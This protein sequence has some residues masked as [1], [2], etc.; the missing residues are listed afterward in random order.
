LAS[1]RGELSRSSRPVR[2]AAHCAI[3]TG[4]AAAAVTGLPAAH[5][6]EPS[7]EELVVTGTRIRQPGVVSSS[8]IYSVGAEEIERQQEPELE[9]ILRLLPVTAPSDGQNVNNGT[10]GAATIDLRGLGSQRTLVLMNGRRMVPFNDD[11]EVDTSMIP[12]ALIQRVDIITGGASAVYGSDAIAGAVNVVLKDDFEGVDIRMNTSQT[13]ESDGQDSWVGVTLGTNAAD[14]AGN[15]VLSLGYQ[16]RDPILLGDRPLGQLGIVTADGSG[17]S[18]YLAGQPPTPAP[19]GCGGPGSVAAGG[20]TTTVPTRV[21]IAGGP[22]LG[23]FRDDG[24]LQAN[25]GVFNFNPFNY[26]QTPLERYN[27]T[28]IGTLDLS[29]G[30]EVYSMFNYG[31]TKVEQQVAPSGV[32]GTGI[33]TPLS[34]PLIGA[35]ARALMISTAEA[36]RLAG[37]VNPAGIPNTST[38]DPNDFLFHNWTDTDGNG[39][40]SAG[41]DLNIQYRRRTGELGARSEDYNN[42][43]FQAVVGLRG[44]ISDNWDYDVSFQ[45][46][47]TNRVLKR[48]GYTN[49]TNFENA[50]QTLDG[51]T[52]LNGDATCVPINVFGGY[53]SITPAMAAYSGATALQQQ[54]Y[55][56]LIGQAF[57]TGSFENVQLPSASSPIA[58]SF[59]V[60]H[61]DES[62]SLTPDECLKLAPTSCLGGAGGYLLPIDG[63]FTVNEAFMEALVPL[64]DG[65]RGAQGL[66]VEL[67][68]RASDYTPS[69]SDDT[70][71]IGLNYRPIET[72]MFR[73]MQQRAARAPNV[74]ELVSPVVIGLD[75]ATQD[76]CSISN[77]GGITPQLQQLCISTGMSAAQVGTVEDIVAGQINIFEGTDLANLPTIEQADTTTVGFVWT[78]DL[79][80]LLN[81]VFSLDYY[82]INIDNPIDD[83]AAQEILDACYQLALVNECAKVKRVGGTLTLDGSGVELLTRNKIYTQAEGIELGFSFGFSVGQGDLT[84]SGTAN[85]YLTHEFRS[86]NELPVVDCNGY[87]GTSCENARPEFRMIERTT[88]NMND[89]S[90]SMQ[91]RHIG[92]V[93]MELPERTTHN[94]NAANG[95]APFYN[96]DAET[97]VDLYASYTFADKYLLSFGAMNVTDID[98]PVVGNE[99]ASTSFNSGNT[100]PSTYDVLGRVYTLQ[101]SMQF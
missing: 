32:F 99:A 79:G 1:S 96:I 5:A 3:L 75:N 44:A 80:A 40:V 15:I 51:V 100:F 71:K 82:D 89:L 85:K 68:F 43:M 93:E 10:Q 46:G 7:V 25:C 62:A 92:A 47:E 63:G 31:K 58:F 49:L 67:G 33:F 66:D 86:L 87:F 39:V 38:T 50:L 74:D 19:A 76:P 14:G 72:L 23:Q 9:K 2:K 45:Y 6:Q 20:S 13:G 94:P 81:P 27:G 64:V 78:P 36:G 57:V 41:D 12:T 53:G 4:V 77:A 30:A 88:W 34:N 29:E 65:K 17:Y 54:D 59:G 37:T 83:F 69:G 35:Q 101:L 73:V 56:Q 91:L 61:R 60:E 18:Q 22:G 55:D 97:Y 84:F 52:C 11:G 28:V 42:E 8:P 26:Y 98:P 90:L 24:T 48:A 95:F 70:W 21:A 16:E